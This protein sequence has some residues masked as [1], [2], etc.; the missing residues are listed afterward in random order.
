MGGY[1]E[2]GGL[3]GARAFG[4]YRL[5]RGTGNVTTDVSNST[6]S[7]HKYVCKGSEKILR[8]ITI[9]KFFVWH[10]VLKFVKASS[11]VLFQGRPYT[12]IA[13]S[14]HAQDLELSRK[15]VE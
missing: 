1:E 2:S 12:I 4:A 14:W 13:T 5:C 10:L 7:A 9:Y 15:K 8:N 11:L 6:R 3:G